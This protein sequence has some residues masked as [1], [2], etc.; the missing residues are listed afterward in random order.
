[1]DYELSPLSTLQQYGIITANI[2]ALTDISF[3]FA[4]RFINSNCLSDKRK[5]ICVF[6]I[7]SPHFLICIDKCIYKNPT[8]LKRALI[9]S[10]ARFNYRYY[11]QLRPRPRWGAWT[12]A[13]T[14]FPP[15]ATN[16]LTPLQGAT[17]LRGIGAQNAPKLLKETL[18]FSFSLVCGISDTAHYTLAYFVTPARESFKTVYKPFCFKFALCRIFGIILIHTD[19]QTIP[20]RKIC[21][22]F[23]VIL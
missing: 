8:K 18:L 11:L 9:R 19:T 23:R 22:T 21:F 6:F 17:P 1:M 12:R 14:A 4:T 16:I 5:L 2:N 20:K 13:Q 10:N 7:K 15:T 3:C